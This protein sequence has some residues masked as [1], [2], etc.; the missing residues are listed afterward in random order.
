MSTETTTRAA[1][2][3]VLVADHG[4]ARLFRA[5]TPTAPLEEVEDLINAE[6]RVPERELASDGPGRLM[7]GAPQR[8][9]SHS[10]VQDPQSGHRHRAE[11]FARRLAARLD[12]LGRGGAIS[13][14]Y[15]IAEPGFLG[16][17]RAELPAR[18]RAKVAGEKIGRAHV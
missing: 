13:N 3:W 8:G 12:E 18:V 10:A 1:C 17:L 4:R 16:V 14:L 9:T 6:A 5:A 11:L 7:G 2:P 15:V